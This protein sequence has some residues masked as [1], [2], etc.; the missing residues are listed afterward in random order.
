MIQETQS[1]K[2]TTITRNRSQPLA[3]SARN[4]LNENSFRERDYVFSSC[5]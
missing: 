5:F 2:R 1:E 3:L 4:G